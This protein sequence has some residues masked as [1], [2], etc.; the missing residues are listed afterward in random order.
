MFN[1]V[2]TLA[3]HQRIDITRP[4]FSEVR[5]IKTEKQSPY[6]SLHTL[7]NSLNIVH[8]NRAPESLQQMKKPGTIKKTEN[9]HLNNGWRDEITITNK[10]EAHRPEF[11]YFVE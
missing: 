3:K 4:L 1:S 2:V 11:L 7:V 8:F 6:L 5:Q 10:Y 9:D